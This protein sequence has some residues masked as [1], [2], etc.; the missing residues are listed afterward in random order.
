MTN[1]VGNNL[2]IT[3]PEAELRRFAACWIKPSGER[4]PR[5]V[6]GKFDINEPRPEGEIFLFIRPADSTKAR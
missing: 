5:W 2:T 3:G 6:E 1:W 4:F